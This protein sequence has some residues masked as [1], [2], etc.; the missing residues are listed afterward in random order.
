MC[1]RDSARAVHEQAPWEAGGHHVREELVEVGVHAPWGR[2]LV[3]RVPHEGAAP[4]HQ[5]MSGSSDTLRASSRYRLRPRFPCGKARRD[6]EGLPQ[7]DHDEVLEDPVH[8]HEEGGRPHAAVA[9]LE[10]GSH[11][12]VDE[13]LESWPKEISGLR[14]SGYPEAA[15]E[16]RTTHVCHALTLQKR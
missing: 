11:A 2:L 14:R 7:R 3:F 4:S 13:A 15:G 16:L 8:V 6:P 12:T 5:D 1:R 9:Q 10:G